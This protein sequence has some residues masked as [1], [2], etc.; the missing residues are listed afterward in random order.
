MSTIEQESIR[1]IKYNQFKSNFNLLTEIFTEGDTIVK[2]SNSL[3][4]SIK[5]EIDSGVNT[6]WT[7]QDF[8]D[9]LNIR[10]QVLGP[11][12]GNISFALQ[13]DNYII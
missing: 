11:I 1:L 7:K 2:Y 13:F 9:M 4:E 12:I 3:L 10:N 8:N 5:Q 6:A